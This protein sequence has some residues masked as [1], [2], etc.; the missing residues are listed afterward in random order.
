MRRGEAKNGGEERRW[1]E[2]RKAEGLT[3]RGFAGAESAPVYLVA[4]ETALSASRSG[5]P[6]FVR[7]LAGA[8]GRRQAA[9]RLVGWRA[10][11]QS[12]RPLPPELS[13]G[14]DAE[15]LRVK[16]DELGRCAAGWTDPSVGTLDD[17][18][19]GMPALHEL[20]APLAPPPGAWIVLPEVLYEGQAERLLA[21]VQR[22]GWRLAVVLHDLLAV[23]EPGF[24]PPDVPNEHDRYLRACSRADLVLPVSEFTADDWRTYTAAKGLVPGRVEV[25]QPG[26][27]TC[28]RFL[29]DGPPSHDPAAPVRM[30]CVSAVESRKN[31]AALLA[32]YDLVAAA[33]PEVRLELC[34]VGENRRGTGADAVI[35]EA[36]TR[37]PGRI[38]WYEFVE[39]GALRQLYLECDFTVFPSV[40]EGFGLPIVEGLWFKRPCVCANF[41]AMNALAAGGGCITTDVRDPRALAEAM[42]ALVDSPER[43]AGLAGEIDRRKMRTWEE[44]AGE[45]LG[46][47]GAG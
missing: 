20:P 45:V 43:L 36:M 21:Y 10:D 25:C 46:L 18:F 8:C 7:C 11:A 27:D 14:L 19:G 44:Y 37:H 33:R 40:L 5:V 32:A 34:L 41:G 15:G 2:R 24:F 6:T 39:S 13:V 29:T 4:G 22:H 9:V 38:T 26:A 12:L 17:P 31:H 16:A 3:G 47:L 1:E 42:L 23:N 35:H 28:V 30:L